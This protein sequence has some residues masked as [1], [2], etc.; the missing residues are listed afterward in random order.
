[1]TAA[2]ARDRGL[3]SGYGGLRVLDGLSFN[4]AE[5][6]FLAIVGPNGHGKTTLAE[7]HFRPV[8]RE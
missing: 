5:G 2:A 6:E 1:M 3:V 8:G 4:V 7:D